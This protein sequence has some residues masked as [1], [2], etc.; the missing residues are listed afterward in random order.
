[1]TVPNQTQAGLSGHATLTPESDAAVLRT[2]CERLRSR[3]RELEERHDQD[4][5]TL[6]Q[7]ESYR[8]SLYAVAQRMFT[9]EDLH[10]TPEE[11]RDMTE[12]K[13]GLPLE[14]F[15]GELAKK[16]HGL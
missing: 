7:L 1:M 15:I 5:Q 13:D 6:A 4:Q 16:A 11:V 9:D 10:F 3:T 12:G 8:R 14:A 2:E